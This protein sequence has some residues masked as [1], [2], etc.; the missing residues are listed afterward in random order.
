ME[1]S[2]SDHSLLI[3]VDDTGHE[4]L[5]P[6]HPV[7]GLGGCAIMAGDLERVIRHPWQEVRRQMRG[8]ADMSLHAAT[9]GHPSRRT[10]DPFACRRS[11]GADA[12]PRCA[13]L[14]FPVP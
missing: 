13:T 5:V 12:S 7:Y 4:S 10:R 2:V 11:A 8:S 1:L 9:L 6:G 3:F 14:R